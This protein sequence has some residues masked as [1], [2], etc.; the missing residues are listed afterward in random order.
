[1]TRRRRDLRTHASMEIK[2]AEAELVVAQNE[3]KHAEKQAK[4]IERLRREWVRIHE[5][6]HL[7]ALFLDDYRSAK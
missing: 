5:E 3:R 7:S 1:M 4:I 6:N 2:R